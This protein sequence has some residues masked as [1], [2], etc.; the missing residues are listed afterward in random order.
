MSHIVHNVFVSLKVQTITT[1][2]IS[3]IKVNY[4][5]DNPTFQRVHMLVFLNSISMVDIYKGPGYL[6]MLL[7]YVSVKYTL[8]L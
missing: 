8:I 3:R 5:Y 7:K 1:S 6:F 2:I 4:L